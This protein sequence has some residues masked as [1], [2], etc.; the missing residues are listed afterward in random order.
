MATNHRA[1]PYQLDNLAAAKPPTGANS[2]NINDDGEQ[3]SVE[4]FLASF[5]ASF[6]AS[7]SQLV[8]E[9]EKKIPTLPEIDLHA[10]GSFETK[11]VDPNFVSKVSSYSRFIFRVL[12]F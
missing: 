7:A 5:D 1:A 8:A 4:A 3:H 9:P 11:D 12:S 6:V 2:K 10:I